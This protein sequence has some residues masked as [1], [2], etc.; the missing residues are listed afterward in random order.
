MSKRRGDIVLLDELMDLVGIDAS[1]WFLVSRSHDQTIE[2][3]IELAREQSGKNP[4]FYVQYAHARIAAIERGAGDRANGAAPDP[5]LAPEPSEAALVRWLA[6]FPRVAGEAADLRAPH[7]IAA[8]ATDLAAC[9]HAFYRDCRVLDDDDLAR[10]QSRLALCRAA[11]GVLASSL[12]LLGVD[13]PD[14]M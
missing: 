11:R 7:R 6:E 10:T 14:E 5:S 8:Y 9:F 4:V 3:D 2:L 12:D 1:R 13:A